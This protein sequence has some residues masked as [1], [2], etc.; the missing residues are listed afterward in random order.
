MNISRLERKSEEEDSTTITYL[1]E[2]EV[3]E[4]LGVGLDL[5]DTFQQ[6]VRS[7]LG[8]LIQ[9]KCGGHFEVSF[10]SQKRSAIA[11]FRRGL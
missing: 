2:E 5:V 10:V 7:L 8:P 6:K 3:A 11:F 1:E 9:E 4:E